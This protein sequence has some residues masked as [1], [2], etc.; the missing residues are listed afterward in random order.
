MSYFDKRIYCKQNLKEQDR[1]EMEF[2]VELFEEAI[3]NALDESEMETIHAGTIGKIVEEVRADFAGRL[4]EEL[5]LAMQ[6]L[7][8]STIDS[9]EED[10]EPVEDPETFF[11]EPEE[12]EE[13]EGGS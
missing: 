10:A 12:E 1:N 5:G 4:R 7:A 11:Y 9:Y 8:V 2:Y 13:A 3:E 6:E